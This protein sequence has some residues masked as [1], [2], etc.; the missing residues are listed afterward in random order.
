[1]PLRKVGPALGVMLLVEW[2]ERR[3]NVEL[4]DDKFQLPPPA[5]LPSCR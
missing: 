5:G 1:M 3:I 2:E 4:G